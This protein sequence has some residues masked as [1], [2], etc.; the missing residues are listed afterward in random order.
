MLLGA[1]FV[2]LAAFWFLLDAF[3]L[4]L[5]AFWVLL[6]ASWAPLGASWAPLGASWA[7]LGSNFKKTLKKNTFFEAN[8]G[9]KMEPQIKKNDVKKRT[10]FEKGCFFSICLRFLVDLGALKPIIF[11]QNLIKRIKRRFCKNWAPVEA[12]CLFFRFRMFH[13]YKKSTNKQTKN[14]AQKL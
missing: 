7:P 4:L 1:F 2:L 9:A 3:W 14:E 13:N 12:P 10:C 11:N 5:G 6:G 8:L